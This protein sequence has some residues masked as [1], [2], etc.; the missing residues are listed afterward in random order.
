[1]DRYSFLARCMWLL[2]AAAFGI[3][4]LQGHG[5]DHVSSSKFT[6][7]TTLYNEKNK[8]RATEFITCMEKNLQH[9]S[10]DTIHVLYDISKDDEQES[11]ILHYLKSRNIKISYIT[12]RAAFGY[13]FK[14]ANS[15]YPHRRII[16]SNADIFFNETLTL[17]EPCDL[18]N[19]FL[20]LTRWD[21]RNNGA[22]IEFY[23]LG[24]SQDVW[25]FQTPLPPFENDAIKM[26][27]LGC[28]PAIAYQA[29]HSG[30]M[31]SNPSLSIQCCHLHRSQIRNYA[32]TYL[33]YQNLGKVEPIPKCTIFEL[34]ETQRSLCLDNLYFKAGLNKPLLIADDQ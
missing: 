8:Y 23:P 13:F 26:G 1:M 15:E 25:I 14:I 3:H 28:D 2:T 16:V 24:F 7:L 9:P 6:L 29:Q 31:L 30:L 21:V 4:H 34:D 5:S 12:E 22:L 17:L 32:R 18:H 19:K 10:I 11:A 20:A 33:P 27:I